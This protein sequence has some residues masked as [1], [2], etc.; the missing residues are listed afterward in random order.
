MSTIV[1][2]PFS[3][4]NAELS[5]IPRDEAASGP[6]ATAG[7]GLQARAD[8]VDP[9][10]GTDAGQKVDMPSAYVTFRDKERGEPIGTYLVSLW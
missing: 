9:V 7:I 8:R 4:P 10:S 3:L 2:S 1:S 6:L 5:R